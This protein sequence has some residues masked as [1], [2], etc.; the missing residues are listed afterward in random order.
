[1]LDR[2][3]SDLLHGGARFVTEDLEDALDTRLTEGAK[4]PQIRPPDADGLR[5]HSQGLDDICATTEA[6]VDKHRDTAADC[7]DDFRQD[8][9]RREAVD[10]TPAAVRNNNSVDTVVGGELCVFPR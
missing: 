1:M 8:L 2:R 9:D 3:R 7:F 4:A 6:A 5:A 10:D